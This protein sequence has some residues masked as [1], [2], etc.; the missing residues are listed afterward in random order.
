MPQL[1]EFSVT[2][3]HIKLAKEVN[4]SWYNFEWGAAGH[5]F[6]RPYGNGDLYKDM[7]NALG[8]FEYDE[9]EDEGFKESERE[10][11]DKIHKEMKTV[12]EISITTQSLKVGTYIKPDKYG[13]LPWQYNGWFHG[14][15]TVLVD[16]N[17]CAL[18]VIA[19]IKENATDAALINA[20]DLIR[21]AV[22][23][24]DRKDNGL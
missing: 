10:A 21:S 20:C 13:L 19:H 14:Q 12:I 1:T 8:W 6:K 7:N 24:K 2:D 16:E 18:K 17:I 5:D 9:D 15:G 3:E 22:Q 4:I 11:F 23:E